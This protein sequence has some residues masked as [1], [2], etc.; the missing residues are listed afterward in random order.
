MQGEV[1]SSSE[2][3]C[4]REVSRAEFA[5]PRRIISSSQEESQGAMMPLVEYRACDTSG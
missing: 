2:E 5:D 1:V 3:E 4:S